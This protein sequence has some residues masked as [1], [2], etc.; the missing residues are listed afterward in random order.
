MYMFGVSQKRENYQPVGFGRIASRLGKRIT[1]FS[2]GL[3]LGEECA[4][5]EL[6]VIMCVVHVQRI[7]LHQ[8]KG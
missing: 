8:S 2:L 6:G 3:N 5:L 4:A 1:A 7:P